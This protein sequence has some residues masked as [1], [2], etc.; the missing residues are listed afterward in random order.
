MVWL[1]GNREELVGWKAL[2]H[3]LSSIIKCN[4]RDAFKYVI[5]IYA[6]TMYH[7]MD[8]RSKLDCKYF[9]SNNHFPSEPSRFQQYEHSHT[10][11]SYSIHIRA[12][13]RSASF[14]L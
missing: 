7:A 2:Q 3:T 9:L 10:Y 1:C 8:H 11:E 5:Y 6:R 13:H 12:L 14:A 4:T